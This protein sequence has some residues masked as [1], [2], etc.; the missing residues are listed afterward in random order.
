MRK[1]I[2]TKAVSVATAA[3][4]TLGAFP[5]AAG[6]SQKIEQSSKAVGKGIEEAFDTDNSS[7][8]DNP[9]AED[10]FGMAI[11]P[12]KDM[13]SDDTATSSKGFTQAIINYAIIAAGITIIGQIIQL[14]M[15]NMPR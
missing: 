10:V 5:A 11:Q 15:A 6:A 13:S 3:A 9:S 12:F 1:T 7:L 8:G 4:L 2:V 14:V